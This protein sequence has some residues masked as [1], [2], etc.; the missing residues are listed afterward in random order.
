MPPNFAIVHQGSSFR[1][2]CAYQVGHHEQNRER[3]GKKLGICLKS[4][5]LRNCV[6]FSLFL[7]HIDISKRNSVYDGGFYHSVH[8]IIL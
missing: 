3:E 5:H 2:K 6:G 4:L 1:A 8:S 7:N